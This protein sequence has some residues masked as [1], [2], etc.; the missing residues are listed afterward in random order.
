MRAV[1]A[2][3][4][5]CVAVVAPAAVAGLRLRP[6]SDTPPPF[7]NAP[8]PG[9]TG[10]PPP[11]PFTSFS[12]WAVL[13]QNSQG[14]HQPNTIDWSVGMHL[15]VDAV[16]K[17]VCTYH[18]QELDPI[19]PQYRAT[20][21]AN[22]SSGVET[23]HL[24]YFNGSATNCG[25]KPLPAGAEMGVGGGWMFAPTPDIH[26][27]L[28]WLEY[29]I[30]GTTNSSIWT[31]LEQV[32]A[33]AHRI[34]TWNIQVDGSIPNVWVNLT[35]DSATNNTVILTAA[36]N[37]YHATTG[38]NQDCLE[39]TDCGKLTCVVNTQASAQSIADALGWVCTV[40]DCTAINQGGSHYYPNSAV[41]HGGWAFNEYYQANSNQGSGACNFQGAAE[42]VV[43]NTA[44]Q[45]CNASANATDAQL[46][47]ALQWV[48][49][50]NGIQD[51]TAIQPG[52]SHFLPNTTRAHADWAF[53]VYFQAYKCVPNWRSCDFGG[54]GV[55]VP[56]PKPPATAAP[57][58]ASV[59]K[60]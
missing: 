13:S 32:N 6:S 51:C 28:R 1:L 9:P 41:A 52:G 16:N 48:C 36:Y 7:T 3:L 57:T 18:A 49:G 5:L 46:G 59:A 39:T 4:L 58:S 17:L 31:Y 35:Y 23:H 38:V 24:E 26:K 25:G 54:V 43:C 22:Y 37:G 14:T 53:N 29:T 20:V 55:V 45:T 56:C 40:E 8:V 2:S 47:T 44:C 30:V 19:T 12:T 27:Q 33:T 50:P 60:P 15:Q 10:P 11:L 42:L 34:F 21:L